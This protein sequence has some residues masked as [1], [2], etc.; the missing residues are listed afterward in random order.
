MNA[1]SPFII[2]DDEY[3]A[4]LRLAL[5]QRRLSHQYRQ[6]ARADEARGDLT[7]YRRNTKEAHRL[8]QCAKWHLN[9]ARHAQPEYVL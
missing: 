5:T 3:A 7:A 2:A 4:F 9:R 8:W 6:W 1:L